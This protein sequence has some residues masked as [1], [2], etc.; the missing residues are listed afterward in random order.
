MA[1]VPNIPPP[2]YMTYFLPLALG[3]DA[4]AQLR[5]TLHE[6]RTTIEGGTTGLR[7]WPA[8]LVLADFLLANPGAPVG[9]Q[10][11]IQ[12][13]LTNMLQILREGSMF[14]NSDRALGSS[15]P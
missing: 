13:G 1:L 11:P 6:S 14:W 15:A 7:T 4:T 5:L 10:G 12:L 8:S 9:A 3:D 2:S